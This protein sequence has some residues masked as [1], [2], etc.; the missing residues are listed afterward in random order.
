[1]AKEKI[2]LTEDIPVTPEMTEGAANLKLANERVSELSK[3]NQMLE[4]K[5]NLI[6]SQKT[7]RTKYLLK[8]SEK[9]SVY[10]RGWLTK[11]KKRLSASFSI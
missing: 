7:S 3:S 10:K 11:R 1:M 5:L 8:C 6:V 2:S 9:L 4:E